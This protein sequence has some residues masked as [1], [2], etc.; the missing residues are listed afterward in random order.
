LHQ[1]GI[2]HRDI[3]PENLLVTAEGRLKIT[4]FGVA[5]VFS[6][7]HPGLKSAPGTVASKPSTEVRKCSPGICGSIP[8]CS[9]EVL[10]ENGESLLT[11]ITKTERSPPSDHH[12][13]L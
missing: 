1:N 5:E 8:Y 12:R 2:A 10:A 9:P 11:M 13:G 4:D 7:T 3:K 6:G